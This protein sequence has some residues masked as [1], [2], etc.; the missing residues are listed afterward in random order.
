MSQDPLER[1][2]W[3][4][5]IFASCAQFFKEQLPTADFFVEG[6]EFKE[7]NIKDSVQFRMDGPQIS[8]ISSTIW[9]VRL[10][11]NIYAQ[12][13]IRESSW[14]DIHKLVG[15]VSAAFKDIP[16]Y[17]FGKVEEDARNNDTL[18]DCLR[19]VQELTGQDGAINVTHFGQVVQN[20]KVMAATIAG[21]YI[22]DH[23]TDIGGI[24]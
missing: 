5:W 22:V 2:L 16:V 24:A 7:D 9:R 15:L 21:H 17:R 14:Q 13:V 18:W 8:Q 6:Q 20:T 10:E 23:D 12:S 4:R 1:D 19:L 11:V 3:P